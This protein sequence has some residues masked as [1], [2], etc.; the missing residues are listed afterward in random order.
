MVM[1]TLT[2]QMGQDSMAIAVVLVP[3]I[4]KVTQSWIAPGQVSL[5]HE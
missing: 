3:A 4:R 5:P 1:N 2:F